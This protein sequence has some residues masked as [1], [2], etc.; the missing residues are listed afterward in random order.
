MNRTYSMMIARMLFAVSMGAC[1]LSAQDKPAS[2]EEPKNAGVSI[3]TQNVTGF[4]KEHGSVGGYTKRW[5]LGDLPHYVPKQQVSGT[6]QVWGNNYIKDG[7]LAEYWQEGFK[8]FQPGL[9]IDYHLPTTGI[10][11]PALSCGVADVSMSR[12]AVIMD[13]LTF[14]QVYHHSVTEISAVTGSYDVYGWMPAFIIVVNHE[15][16]LDRISVKQ[17]DGVFGGMRLGGYDGSVWHTEYPYARGPEEN[18]RTWGQLGLTGEWADKPIHTGGQTL[19]G[20]NTTQFS[21][22]ILCGSDQFAEGYRAYANYITPDGKINSWSLQARRAIAAD[23][24]AMYY[25]SPMSMGP[26]LKELSI[27]GRNGGPFVPRTLETVHD[28][29]YPLYSQYYFYLNREPGKPVEPKGYEF[30]HYILSQEG[31]EEVQREGR[32]IPLT[33]EVVKEQLKKLD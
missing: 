22:A 27:Q 13:L 14:E 32:Y 21:D 8:K 24:F 11:I 15:N 12:K 2:S 30:L 3:W 10:A 26:E 5:D 20:N 33:A 1:Q 6:L 25:V 29:S 23:R 9:K 7:Y 18:I 16:P 19:R 4:R 28:R 17:L 31:Q